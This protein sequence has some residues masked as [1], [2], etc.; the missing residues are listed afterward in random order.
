A[1][2]LCHAICAEHH[3]VHHAIVDGG[4]EL[5]LG[6]DVVVEGALAETVDLAQLGDAGGVVA[7]SSEDL[8][9]RVDDG[10]ATRLPL[11]AAFRLVGGGSSRHG[12]RRY[13]DAPAKEGCG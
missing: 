11:R 9:R 1:T 2:G 8:C 4:E 3:L 7:A 13:S 5:L 12:V 10:V 6:R